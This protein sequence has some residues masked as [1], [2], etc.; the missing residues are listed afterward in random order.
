M[1]QSVVLS[2]LGL[3][4]LASCGGGGGGDGGAP[5]NPG[6]GGG[7]GGGTPLEATFDSI[8]TNIFTAI[9][10]SCHTAASAPLGLRLDAVNSFGLLVG[11]ASSQVPGLLRVDP[12]DPDNSYLIQ[13]L[14][15]T[16]A[17]GARMPLGGIALSQADINV[18]R[19][20]ISD[21]ALAM[22]APPPAAPIRLTSLSLI[23]GSSL[24]TL[25]VS[26]IAMF[27]RELDASSVDA[28]TFII[29]RSGGDGTFGDGNEVAITAASIAVNPANP[30][31]AIFDLTGV[32]AE[33]D[34]YRVRLLGAGGATIRDLDANALDGEFSGAFPSGDGAAGGDFEAEF[35]I[36]ALVATIES[37]QSKI[38]STT[39]FVGCHTGIGPDLPGS[40]DLSDT[41]ASF[42]S[43]V[44]MA[45]MQVPALSRIMPL[46]PDA[47]YLI[48]KLEGT[49][50]VGM[51]M[52]RGG[53]FLD[54][55]T[56][57]VIRQWITDGAAR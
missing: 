40:M 13:K 49:A 52:P 47:S 38:F 14:E 5:S 57:D 48:Q 32:A 15:G 51:Q 55:A 29:E 26:V 36:A 9:C 6:G 21:G 25:P 33:N 39:C 35:I 12:G 27:D 22:P 30:M 45:S 7:G 43:L 42:N 8:Q 23:P 44:M 46:N 16:A 10:I 3:F 19:Q 4:M 34:T 28:T 31:T 50:A 24:D 17:V 1:K 53:P 41:D 56:I 2:I 11:I 54:Q 18:V 20:W 37:I